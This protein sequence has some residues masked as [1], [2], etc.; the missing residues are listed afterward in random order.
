MARSRLG[1]GTRV[2]ALSRG[3]VDQIGRADHRV[4][5]FVWFSIDDDRD[6]ARARLRETVAVALQQDFMRS[7]LGHLVTAGPSEAVLAEVTVSGTPTD[8]AAAV[9]ALHA[10]GADAVVLQSVPRTEVEQL[11]RVRE[12]LLPLLVD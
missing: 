8:C 11:E 1:T 2:C 12:D 5:V 3:A 7:Q 9:R 10:A 4:A 6:T